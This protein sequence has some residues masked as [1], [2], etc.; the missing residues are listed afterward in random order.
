VVFAGKWDGRDVAIKRMLI[1]FNEIASQETKLL[2]ESDDHPNG[3]CYI[4]SPLK[5]CL[6][7]PHSH[8]LL[9][10]TATRCIPL[11]RA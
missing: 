3:R 8:P 9:C 1:Q 10:P 11:Y 2:R 4:C 6:L 7:M 5:F